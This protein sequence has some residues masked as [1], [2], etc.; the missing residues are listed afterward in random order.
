MHDVRDWAVAMKNLTDAA[1]LRNRLVA[2]LEEASL[3]RDEA[4]RR[5]LLTFV[6]A[7][8]GFCRR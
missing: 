7:G 8:G 4:S 2:A 1:L 3:R 6:I 5:E